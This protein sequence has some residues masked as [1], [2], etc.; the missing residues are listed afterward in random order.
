MFLYW[1]FLLQVACFAVASQ[2]KFKAAKQSCRPNVLVLD[3]DENWALSKLVEPIVKFEWVDANSTLWKPCV[4]LYN[5]F[6]KSFCEVQNKNPSISL[7]WCLIS[8]DRMSSPSY[9]RPRWLVRDVEA[10]VTVYSVLNVCQG[11]DTFKWIKFPSRL[12]LHQESM[13][14]ATF[15]LTQEVYKCPEYN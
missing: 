10:M 13:S 15:I 12:V 9:P 3:Y 14:T 1:T 4:T 11:Q 8:N 6:W 5:I 2:K 7:C